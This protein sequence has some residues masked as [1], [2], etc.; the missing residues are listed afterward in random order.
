MLEQFKNERLG[1]N[2][3]VVRKLTNLVG[4]TVDGVLVGHRNDFVLIE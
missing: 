4:P 3:S 2:D 1:R